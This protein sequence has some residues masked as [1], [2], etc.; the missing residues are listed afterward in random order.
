V[1]KHE[2]VVTP[3]LVQDERGWLRLASQEGACPTRRRISEIGELWAD[4]A[5]RQFTYTPHGLQGDDSGAS[6]AR[7]LDTEEG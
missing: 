7:L 2:E 1:V 5:G 3:R 4:R 6:L